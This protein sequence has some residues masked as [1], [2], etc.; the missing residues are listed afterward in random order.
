M[1]VCSTNVLFAGYIIKWSQLLLITWL[2]SLV[3]PASATVEIKMLSWC[4]SQILSRNSYMGGN[5]Q[6]D[7]YLKNLRPCIGD[8]NSFWA[9][10]INMVWV[11]QVAAYRFYC[12]LTSREKSLTSWSLRQISCINMSDQIAELWEKNVP[13][14]NLVSTDTNGHFLEQ[15]SQ[16]RC[17]YSQKN[18]RIICCT[19]NKRLHVRCFRLYHST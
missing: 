10:L 2:S 16:G 7:S 6:L 13:I 8:K 3:K 5:D 12:H 4:N 18:C 19:C 9:Q 15:H 14:P 1:S 11:L 17:E